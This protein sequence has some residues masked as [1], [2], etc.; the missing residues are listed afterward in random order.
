LNS[1]F[2]LTIDCFNVY[3]EKSLENIWSISEIF[4]LESFLIFILLIFFEFPFF[5]SLWLSLEEKIHSFSE[6]WKIISFFS[7][8]IAGII[9][10]TLDPWIQSFLAFFSIFFYFTTLIFL[11]KR[12]NLKILG[13]LNL[14]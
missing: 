3:G 10:P 13:F 12:L 1:F 11:Q 7:F 2:P 6:F 4:F 14:A 5:L 9:T 8:V